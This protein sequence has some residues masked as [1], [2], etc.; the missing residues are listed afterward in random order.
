MPTTDAILP[1][2]LFTLLILMLSLHGLS[3]SGH[4]PREHRAPALRSL[5]GT[6]ILHGT[7]LI[8]LTSLI[9]GLWTAWHLI[10]WYVAVIAG[11]LGILA[12]P[13]V[14]QEFSDSF[15]DDRGSLLSF[16]GASV[17]LAIML[18]WLATNRVML[19]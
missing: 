18:L 19:W 7:I 17:A 6:V 2:V 14:L 10:P 16:A 4:F 12:A 11:G 8:A 15:V 13:L 1:L 5:L 3:A 9:A